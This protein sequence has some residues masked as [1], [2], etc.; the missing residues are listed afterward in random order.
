MGEACMAAGTRSSLCLLPAHYS[1]GSAIYLAASTERTLAEMRHRRYQPIPRELWNPPARL[2]PIDAENGPVL[3]Y[4]APQS[5]RLTFA[6]LPVPQ[7]ASTTADTAP[8]PADNPPAHDA[9]PSLSE[10]TLAEE[11]DTSTSTMNFTQQPTRPGPRLQNTAK[12]AL[13]NGLGGGWNAGGGGFGGGGGGAGGLGGG[14][15]AGIGGAMAGMGRPAQ[16]SGFAQVMGGGQGP[17]DMR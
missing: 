12:S 6:S 13:G 9:P 3:E 16:L 14:L 8:T 1:A 4:T 5:S 2:A 7:P 10:Q 17:I 15:G 11:T